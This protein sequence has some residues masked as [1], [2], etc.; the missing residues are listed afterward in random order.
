MDEFTSEEAFDAASKI[1]H[2]LHT[3]F[4]GKPPCDSF[5]Q[6]WAIYGSHGA[7][8]VPLMPPALCPVMP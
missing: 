2:L 7:P 6:A 4:F 3:P 8:G 1:E 5:A